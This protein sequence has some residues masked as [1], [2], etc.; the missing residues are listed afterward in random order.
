VAQIDG[1]A[2]AAAQ[3]AVSAA[4]DAEPELKTVRAA[5]GQ[6][7]GGWTSLQLSVGVQGGLTKDG[8][9]G[10]AGL[11]LPIELNPLPAI[12]YKEINKAVAQGIPSAEG[13]RMKGHVLTILKETSGEVQ[14][15]SSPL[16]FGREDKAIAL[17]ATSMKYAI[18]TVCECG[19]ANCPVETWVT[20]D[21]RSFGEDHIKKMEQNG[22]PNVKKMDYKR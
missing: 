21:R 15:I 19:V 17:I 14:A 22:I 18:R 12:E 16:G 9:E 8:P 6:A 7:V 1:S 2:M 20:I 11:S 5:A 3:T 4:T 13:S 10:G